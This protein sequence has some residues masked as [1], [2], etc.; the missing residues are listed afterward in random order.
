MRRQRRVSRMTKDKEQQYNEL[1]EIWKGK[2]DKNIDR[3]TQK[4]LANFN[5][6]LFGAIKSMGSDPLKSVVKAEL[7]QKD[8]AAIAKGK[9]RA[10]S[11]AQF[12]MMAR[13]A[14][15]PL[16]HAALTKAHHGKLQLKRK[17][18]KRPAGK[19]PRVLDY[20]GIEK[21]MFEFNRA[22]KALNQRNKKPRLSSHIGGKSKNGRLQN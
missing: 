19:K 22:I 10:P 18:H 7:V 17:K 4:A 16:R 3:G 8:R 9:A 20:E 21:A 2:E 11:D 14:L 12:D 5:K 6:K 13:T 1:Y 15:N